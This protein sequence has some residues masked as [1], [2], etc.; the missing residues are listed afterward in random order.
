MVS[1]RSEEWEQFPQAA[2][3]AAA[4]PPGLSVA[5]LANATG[6]YNCFLNVVVQCLWNCLDFKQKL[7]MC[8]IRQRLDVEQ[9][10]APHPLVYALVKLFQDLDQA[11]Q[12]LHSGGARCGPCASALA[13]GRFAAASP[14]GGWRAPYGRVVG[15]QGWRSLHLAGLYAARTARNMES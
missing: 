7:R 1:P 10:R 8:L 9:L 4:G 3:P 11:E 15:G 2:Q 5:G 14:I 6:E 12:E 13:A